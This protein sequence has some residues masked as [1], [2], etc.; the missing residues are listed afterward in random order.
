MWPSLRPGRI[1]AKPNL[2]WTM[3]TVYTISQNYNLRIS[4]HF[5]RWFGKVMQYACMSDKNSAEPRKLLHFTFWHFLV[6]ECMPSLTNIRFASNVHRRAEAILL[7]VLGPCEVWTKLSQLS[8]YLRNINGQVCVWTWC[9]SPR[10]RSFFK[11]DK[12]VLKSFPKFKQNRSSPFEISNTLKLF[13][14][15]LPC[16]ANASTNATRTLNWNRKLAQ[17]SGVMWYFP[18]DSLGLIE[19]QLTYPWP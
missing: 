18:D 9:L 1:F 5:A 12:T 10:H 7:W 8:T 15:N 11:F 6:F 17:I 14:K 3:C 4:L 2:C 16:G 19:H 13:N